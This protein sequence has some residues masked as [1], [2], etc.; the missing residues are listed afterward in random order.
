MDAL[1]SHAVAGRVESN[2]HHAGSHKRYP[3]YSITCHVKRKPNFYTWNVALIVSLIMALTFCSFAVDITSPEERLGVTLTLLL[4]SV[5]FKFVVA[6]SLPN[7]S[8]LTYLD[9]Y[10]ISCMV[11]QCV[12]A[13]LNTIGGKVSAENQD[14]FDTVSLCI[15]GGI[16]VIL[17]LIF[18]VLLT[19]KVRKINTFLNGVTK[20]YDRL[21]AEYDEKYQQKKSL[22]SQNKQKTEENAQEDVSKNALQNRKKDKKMSLVEDFYQGNDLSNQFHYSLQVDP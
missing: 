8:Y 6:Q 3:H 11:I 21:A 19:I 15:L 2:Q 5:A 12:I 14:K 20:E 1:C 16:V 7:V 13:I 4:T 18:T 9:Q 17:H 10:V 22:K